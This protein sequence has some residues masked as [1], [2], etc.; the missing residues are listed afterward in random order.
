MP[1]QHQ[2]TSRTSLADISGLA[3]RARRAVA[4][5][6][7][8]LAEQEI[9]LREARAREAALLRQ[10]DQ[11]V[12]TQEAF[13]GLFDLREQAVNGV[14]KLTQRQH[15]IMGMVVAGHLSKIIAW[16][17]GIS[18]RT[19]ENHRAAIMQKTGAKSL[20][21]LARLALA[22]AC[23]GSAARDAGSNSVG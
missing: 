3:P 18:Q 4:G 17:L 5:Y 8:A 20:P 7:R 22:A 16:E 12:R 14:A 23:D 19:V 11:L 15:Q 21:A 9:Q 2:T 6:E 13:R 10:Q 1:L